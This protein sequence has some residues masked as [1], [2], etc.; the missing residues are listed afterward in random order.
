MCVRVCIVLGLPSLFCPWSV[1]LYTR[2]DCHFF[3]SGLLRIILFS[4]IPLMCP[5]V[6]LFATIDYVQQYVLPRVVPFPL[7][8]ISVLRSTSYAYSS[9]LL[10]SCFLN[11]LNKSAR[12]TAVARDEP[13]G[14]CSILIL[15]L[16][17]HYA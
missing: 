2:T 4:P 6:L 1:C 10:F 17:G 5:H 7:F 15:L 3:F 12:P 8:P 13:G 14:L 16:V 11:T 9:S